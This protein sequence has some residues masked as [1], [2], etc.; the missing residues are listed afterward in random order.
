MLRGAP[1]GGDSSR[2]RREKSFE[3]IRVALY[4][5]LRDHVLVCPRLTYNSSR[6][7][8][9]ATVWT[10]S[11]LVAVDPRGPPTRRRHHDCVQGAITGSNVLIEAEVIWHGFRRENGCE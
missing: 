6:E 1:L 8:K 10:H 11:C 5:D 7:G 9:W 4:R 2:S 3:L